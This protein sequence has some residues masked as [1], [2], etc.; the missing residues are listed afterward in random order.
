M[1]DDVHV[2]NT[3]RTLYAILHSTISHTIDCR[4]VELVV[5]V[6]GRGGEDTDAVV[7]SG[8]GLFILIH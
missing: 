1:R 8:A 3:L 2:C 6:R 7:E 5:C 4:M